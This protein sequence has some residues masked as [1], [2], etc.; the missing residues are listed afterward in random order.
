[1]RRPTLTVSPGRRVLTEEDYRDGVL[2]LITRHP[3]VFDAAA[4]SLTA[5]RNA[6]SWVGS[7]AFGVNAFHGAPCSAVSDQALVL[8]RLPASNGRTG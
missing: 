3:D 6:A 4:L 8:A 7:R 2:P 5:F 1:M